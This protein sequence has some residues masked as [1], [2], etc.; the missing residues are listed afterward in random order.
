VFGALWLAL[1]LRQLTIAE[2]LV[3]GRTFLFGDENR[4]GSWIRRHMIPNKEYVTDFPSF[5][6]GLSFPSK[7]H[8]RSALPNTRLLLGTLNPRGRISLRPVS[9]KRLG[10]IFV[11]LESHFLTCI[12]LSY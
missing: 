7:A 3:F 1:S 9:S 8:P 10:P 4:S 5:S 6:S 2:F 12:S 11:A